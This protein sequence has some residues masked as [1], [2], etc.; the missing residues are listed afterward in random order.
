MM[1]RF[2]STTGWQE[3]IA[4]TPSA[5]QPSIPQ[6]ADTRKLSTSHGEASLQA[7][8]QKPAT[9]RVSPP[10]SRLLARITVP[11]A[12]PETRTPAPAVLEPLPQMALSA[13][14][15]LGESSRRRP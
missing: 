14:S 15:V 6:L 2:E 7:V 9:L 4:R 11:A 3:P 5:R 10:D 1:R 13:A 8:A 12:S